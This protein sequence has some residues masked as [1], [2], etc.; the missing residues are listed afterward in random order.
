MSVRNS[1]ENAQVVL[2]V[3]LLAV[4]LACGSLGSSPAQSGGDVRGLEGTQ[5][6]VESTWPPTWT[7][8]SSPIPT[9]PPTLAPLTSV[10]STSTPMVIVSGGCGDGLSTLIKAAEDCSPAGVTCT[11]ST[12]VVAAVM[13]ATMLY[14]IKGMEADVC[15]VYMRLEE[16]EVRFTGE[17]VQWRLESGDTL[18]EIRQDEEEANLALD[19]MEG[20][21]GVCRF[22]TMEDLEGWLRALEKQTYGGTSCSLE[23][24]GWQCGYEGDYECE[25][26]L[27]E[28]L[29]EW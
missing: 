15:V 9:Y 4:G 8:T 12:N 19:E 5:P 24:G 2:A 13:T 22:G 27:F 1:G 23:D 11:T 6:A 28:S 7:P 16:I 10:P 25:G 26:D 18:E 3:A 29:V 20:K 17:G 14:E 21:D